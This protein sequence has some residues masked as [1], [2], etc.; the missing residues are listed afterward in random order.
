MVPIS[1][2]TSSRDMPMPLS[3]TV[4][5]RGLL[6]GLELDVQVG[7]VGAEL[8]VAERSE[9]QLVQRVGGV[10]D[11]LAQEDV[12]V[13]VDRVDHQ[14]QQL[15]GLRLELERLGRHRPWSLSGQQVTGTDRAPRSSGPSGR[16][17]TPDLRRTPEMPVT[18]V[19]PPRRRTAAALP[20]HAR[21]TRGRIVRRRPLA[22]VARLAG[23]RRTA[24]KNCRALAASEAV[25]SPDLGVRYYPSTPPGRRASRWSST[26]ATAPGTSGPPSSPP[27]RTCAASTTSRP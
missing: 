6:V 14:L 13:R 22:D 21:W 7:H 17:R 25:L 1:S 27:R 2:T 20:P 24:R 18:A 16:S 10:G 12:L 8:V 23:H 11:Q 9:P 4:S 19:L 3:R 15:A 5:V 26:G